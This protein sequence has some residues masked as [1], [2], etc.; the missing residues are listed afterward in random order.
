MIA[1][2][3]GEVA[4]AEQVLEFWFADAAAV[5]AAIEGRQ[6]V[7]FAGG[8]AF[9][10]SC[11]EGFSAT[12]AAAASGALDHWT[13]SPRGRLALIVLLD[14]F[15]RNIYRGTAAA[16]D[17]DARALAACRE[18][19]EQGHD[20]T[21]SLIERTIFYMPMEHAEDRDIQTLSIQHFEALAAEAPEELRALM[22]AN[23]GYARQHR[24]I[25]ERFGRFPHR[26]NVLGR[27]STADEEAYLAHDAPRFGQ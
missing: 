12:M 24:D 26:N 17:Q 6:R 11:S 5:P 10:R 21:L 7:W 13:A 1:H 19:I 27:E 3:T 20:R 4:D 23:A 15:S 14:Q 2:A 16:F 9:D 22:R 8:A 25:V 18:G